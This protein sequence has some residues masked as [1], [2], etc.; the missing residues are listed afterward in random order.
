MK[1]TFVNPQC[2]TPLMRIIEA[3][4][5]A[6]SW[7]RPV[8]LYVC[9]GIRMTVR[10]RLSVFHMYRQFQEMERARDRRTGY[11]RPSHTVIPDRHGPIVKNAVRCGI[12]GAPA[13]RYANRFECQANAGHLGDLFMAIFSDLSRDAL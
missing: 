6:L 9:Y 11:N 5:L 10:S 7:N 4:L 12:C 2:R 1:H 8:T 13:D 3:Q